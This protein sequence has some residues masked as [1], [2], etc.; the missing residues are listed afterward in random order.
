MSRAGYG[1]TEAWRQI[2][3]KRSPWVLGAE[4]APA[5]IKLM[6]AAEDL[7]HALTTQV[8]VVSTWN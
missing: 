7:L 1:D 4:A 8:A 2:G 5:C 6:Y 3:H